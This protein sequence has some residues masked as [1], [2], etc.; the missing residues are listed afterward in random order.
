MIPVRT[1]PE[2]A[3]A[4]PGLPVVFVKIFSLSDTTV[5]A[6]FSTTTE[7]VRWA[8]VVACDLLSVRIGSLNKLCQSVFISPGC[9]VSISFAFAL[10]VQF[11]RAARL[12]RPSASMI[13]LRL[14]QSSNASRIVFGPWP[15]PIP[16]PKA[17]QSFCSAAA[18]QASIALAEMM[19]FLSSASGMVVKQGSIAATI[20]RTVSGVAIRT[21]PEPV[22]SAARPAIAA[23]PDIPRLPAIM[24]IL[25]KSPLWASDFLGGRVGICVIIC[26]IFS[27]FGLFFD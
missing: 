22:R 8:S 19:P 26:I 7:F 17:R 4:M 12:F 20:G 24:Q 23:A 27:P 2:P 16:G 5:A 18:R 14:S 13:S 9:G 21:R 1:S 15:I 3:V 25:P 11:L 6:P 10:E